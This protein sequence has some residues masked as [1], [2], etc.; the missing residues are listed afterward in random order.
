ML[1]SLEPVACSDIAQ[2][3]SVKIKTLSS[4][5]QIVILAREWR[6]RVVIRVV[7]KHQELGVFLVMKSIAMQI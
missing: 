6:T 2:Q 3:H 1:R 7:V 5:G 4:I